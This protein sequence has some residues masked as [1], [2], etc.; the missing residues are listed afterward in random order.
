MRA[1]IGSSTIT[2]AVAL[3]SLAG[4]VVAAD[5]P[6]QPEQAALKKHVETLASPAFAGRRGEG[7]DKAADYVEAAF[8]AVGLEPLFEDKYTQTIPS[9]PA[10]RLT[11][12]NVG[13]KL[14]GSDPKLKDEWVIV[15]AHFDHLGQYGDLLFPGADDNASGTAMLLEV[16][17]CFAK[18]PERPKRSLM[19]VGF[20]MEEDGLFGSRHT[21]PITRPSRLTRWPSSSRPT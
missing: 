9:K 16:A 15:S 1:R 20:D 11:G 17:R 14:I 2:L 19:F 8:K 18:A 4:P 3:V 13:A 5:P 12:H 21:S 10:G 6:L 7:A